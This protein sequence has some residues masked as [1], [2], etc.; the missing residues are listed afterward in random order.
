MIIRPTE[1][2]DFGAIAE[3]TNTFIR[4]TAIHFGYEEQ[5]PGELRRP[6]EA[7]HA[8]HP[9]LTVEIDGRFSGFAKSGVWRERAAYVRTAETTIYMCDFAR[10]GGVGRALYSALLEE[11]RAR[12]F[13]WAIAGITLPNEASVRF[14]EALGYVYVGTFREVGWK[15]GRWHDVGFWER[16]IGG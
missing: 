7:A 11:L 6:W 4:D 13:H 15:F 14:H 2:R 10:R 8:T 12:A 1:A 9:W 5:T 3:L 16:G